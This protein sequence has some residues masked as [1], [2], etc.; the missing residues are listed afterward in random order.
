MFG[1]LNRRA[2]LRS[3]TIGSLLMPGILSELLAEGTDSPS[4][5]D[6]AKGPLAPKPPHYEP[7]AKRVI[8]V[9]ATGGVSHIDTF[10]PKSSANG[11][12]GSGKDKLMGSVFPYQANPRCGTVV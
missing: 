9:F 12:D 2:A 8:F 11:R 1:P 7:R 3:M 10:D 6:S 4:G 5:N